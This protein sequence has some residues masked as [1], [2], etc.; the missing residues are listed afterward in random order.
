MKNEKIE[1]ALGHLLL[2]QKEL[3]TEKI[4]YKK[5]RETVPLTKKNAAK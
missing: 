2:G 1:T 5:S 3:I 4:G